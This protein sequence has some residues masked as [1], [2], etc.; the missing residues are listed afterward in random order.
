M[1]D[2]KLYGNYV[3]IVVAN[4]DPLKKGRVKIFI[5]QLSPNVYNNWNQTSSD[6]KFKFLGENVESP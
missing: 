5:P 2:K 4:N 6:K 3:G 1:N